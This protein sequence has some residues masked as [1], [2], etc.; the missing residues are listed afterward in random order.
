MSQ[1]SEH[2]ILGQSHSLTLLG[3]VRRFLARPAREK[4]IFFEQRWK[5]WFP[6]APTPVDLPFGVQWLARDDQVGQGIREGWFERAELAFVGRFLQ[7]GMTVLDIGAHHGLYTLL[8]SRRVGP[9]GQ[10]IAF[11]PSP[12]ERKALFRHLKLNRCTNVTVQG[13]ALG[14][15]E[16]EAILHIVQG[17]ESGCNSLKPPVVKS[18][19]S[20]VR[21]SVAR[22]DD[23]LRKQGI[24]R[25]DFVKLDVEG[26]ELSVLKGARRLLESAKRPVFL[27][28][29]EDTRTRPWGYLS[30]EIVTMLDSME[31]EWFQPLRDGALAGIGPKREGFEANLVAVPKERKGEVLSL[32]GHRC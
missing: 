8:A 20:P 27:M 9:K 16:G 11:E 14:N 15:E 17:G 21:V 19:T 1:R 2:A 32:L 12:R 26:A 24:E 31:Y 30:C 7:P 3:R 22:L 13:L 25:V 5:R 10:V 4:Y 28:E 23:W 29:V 18:G 6:P